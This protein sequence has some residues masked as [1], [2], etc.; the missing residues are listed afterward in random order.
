MV[1]PVCGKES[2]NVR[3]EVDPY[4]ADIYDDDTP[5]L[6]CDDCRYESAMDI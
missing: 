5:V 6:Q 4:A 2:T 1:C 3:L